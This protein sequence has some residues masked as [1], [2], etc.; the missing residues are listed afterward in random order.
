VLCGGLA[1]L[2]VTAGALGL[3]EHS[4]IRQTVESCINIHVLFGLLLCALIVVRC[5][6]CVGGA[7]SMSCLEVRELSRHLSRVVYLILY[8]AVGLRECLGLVE[9]LALGAASDVAIFDERWRNGPDV[10]GF[11]PHDDFQ[12]FFVC[13]LLVLGGARV[14]V[15]V[16][17]RAA[18]FGVVRSNRRSD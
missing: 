17:D 18:R 4:T 11:N 15:V 10:Q 5:R 1:L 14:L 12:R 13:G 8:G 9:R 16:F 7:W 2:S 6:Q 3:L